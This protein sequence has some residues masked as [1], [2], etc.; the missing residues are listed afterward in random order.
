[1]DYVDYKKWVG[2]NIRVS[3][4]VMYFG[5]SSVYFLL[6]CQHNCI[7]FKNYRFASPPTAQRS[8]CD[9]LKLANWF[10]SLNG[11][12]KHRS[13]TTW[14]KEYYN[15]NIMEFIQLVG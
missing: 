4:Y 1:M 11:V 14:G 3:V 15:N 12:N 2:D 7:S 5:G 8:Y 9:L 6:I 10:E 13:F